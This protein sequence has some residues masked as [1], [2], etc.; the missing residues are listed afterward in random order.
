MTLDQYCHE[1]QQDAEFVAS[2]DRKHGTN[3]AMNGNA[4]EL[5]IYEVSGRMAADVE[6]FV[7][8]LYTRWLQAA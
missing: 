4:M 8:Y 1:K 6:R 2:F 5:L 7:D 3:I